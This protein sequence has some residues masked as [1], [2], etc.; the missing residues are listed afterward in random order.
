MLATICSSRWNR[1]WKLLVV[2]VFEDD[3]ELLGFNIFE[4]DDLA[5]VSAQANAGPDQGFE[6]IFPVGIFDFLP[7]LHHAVQDGRQ[8]LV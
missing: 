6:L 8:H 2:D 3:E 5:D 4:G 7:F 1:P